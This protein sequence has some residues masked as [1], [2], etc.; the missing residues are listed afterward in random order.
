MFCT[1][2]TTTWYVSIFGFT[3]YGSTLVNLQKEFKNTVRDN[4]S[5]L[6]EAAKNAGVDN[7]VVEN[8]LGILKAIPSSTK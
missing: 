2:H 6:K 8:L 5:N 3:L 4:D 1:R 7:T